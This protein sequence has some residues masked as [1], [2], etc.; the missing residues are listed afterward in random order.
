MNIGTVESINNK[1]IDKIGTIKEIYAQ[2]RHMVDYLEKLGIDCRRA[3]AQNFLHI[4]LL[5]DDFNEMETQYNLSVV[6]SLSHYYCARNKFDETQTTNEYYKTITSENF[7]SKIDEYLQKAHVILKCAINEY[8]KSDICDDAVWPFAEKIRKKIIY[9]KSIEIMTK[10]EKSD[11]KTCSCGHKMIIVPQTSELRCEV[12][13]AVKDLPG[14]A[15]DD[16]QIYSQEGGKTKHGT[17]DPSR[18]FRFW[19]ERIQA[20]EIK[21]FPAKDIKKIEYVWERDGTDLSNVYGMREILKEVD[22]TRYNDHAPLLMRILTGVVPPQLNYTLMHKFK[23]KFSKIMDYI[24]EIY[25]EDCKRVNR[26]YYPFFIYK[27]IEDEIE[28][29]H[30]D[31]REI[32]AAELKRMLNYIHLQSDDTIY[33]HDQLYKR[34]CDISAERDRK[35]NRL[36]YRPTIKNERRG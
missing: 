5:A 20:K 23:V 24:R 33:R 28:E 15:F 30:K 26:P 10:V 12:C 21:Q 31:N 32:D 3:L 9:A 1:I 17:Y 19:M 27:I 11:Y 22:L 18:H 16:I 13:P 2:L 35:K 7:P 34:V 14:T 36:K 8:N 25:S 29:A 4:N 6:H